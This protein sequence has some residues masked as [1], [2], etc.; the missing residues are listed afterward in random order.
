MDDDT[1]KPPE[2]RELARYQG[3]THAAPYP[4][5]RMA[6]AFSLID[7]ATELARADDQLA[8]ATGGKLAVLAEQMR[9]LRA[10]AEALLSKAARDLA[11]HRARCNFEKVPGG[12]YHLY[13]KADGSRWFSMVAP[14]E[15]VRGAPDRFVGSYRLEA[16]RSFTD[17][18]EHDELARAE[19]ARAARPRLR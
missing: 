11:L 13:E 8:T 1:R 18:A 6:P 9:A 3:P 17:L 14:E 19:E 16:D 15:W 7:A 2:D 5:S 10:Q 4:L 12:V